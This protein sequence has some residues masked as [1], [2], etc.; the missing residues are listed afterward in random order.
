MTHLDAREKLLDLAY[1]ELS[2]REA[3]E[4]EAHL[5]GCAECRAERDRIA[6]TRAAM[7]RLEPEVPPAAGERILLAAARQAA[8]RQRERS[9]V[10]VPRWVWRVSFTT[11]LVAVVGAV[12][13][14]IVGMRERTVREELRGAP[15]RAA[16][17]AE[18]P[19]AQAPALPAP[20]P[21]KPEEAKVARS[22]ERPA[23][24]ARKEAPPAAAPEAPQTMA[25]RDGEKARPATAAAPAVAEQAPE[26]ERS[27]AQ[28][29]AKVADRAVGA[30][31]PAP[32]AAGAPPSADVMA[33]ESPARPAAKGEAK[34]GSAES[35]APGTGA[36]AGPVASLAAPEPGP[37][38]AAAPVPKE[39]RLTARDW[40]GSPEIEA[41]RRIVRD[42]DRRVRAGKL[43]ASAR[44][45]QACGPSE[46]AERRIYAGADGRAA[47]FVR[48]SGGAEAAL[49]FE[50][51]YDEAGR[52]RYVFIHGGAVNGALL[53]HR[54]WLDPEGNRLWEEQKLRRGSYPFP[55][56]WPDR[57]LWPTAPGAEVLGCGNGAGIR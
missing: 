41:V 28:A 44:P 19:A 31:P 20:V 53:E 10:M 52:L 37:S 30:A 22:A 39:P 56:A 27:L 45:F 57:D 24:S 15:E 34:L 9:G 50:E 36:P 3:A 55:T 43:Q 21:A 29:R 47:K 6:A 12:T 16:P 42:V 25:K 49:T 1:G 51:Y 23:A 11:V 8:D 54:I 2:R 4:V 17:R 40:K 26:A 33:G 14:Q 7:R 13:L 5:A 46:D 35:A 32:A 38:R 48:Q 18:A